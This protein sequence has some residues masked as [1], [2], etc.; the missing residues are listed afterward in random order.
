MAV[1]VG[2][3]VPPGEWDAEQR[4]TGAGRRTAIEQDR[5]ADLTD[6][7]QDDPHIRDVTVEVVDKL[8]GDV[9]GAPWLHEGRVQLVEQIRYP[10]G[11]DASA[12]LDELEKL[13]HKLGIEIQVGD[14]QRV[15][16]LNVKMT[17]ALAGK[18]DPVQLRPA[19]HS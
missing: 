13:C 5:A 15:Y 1:A 9:G 16:C 6:P 14:D 7:G 18:A 2:K 4:H 12:F 19:Y 8:A 17:A 3:A 10:D 11:F